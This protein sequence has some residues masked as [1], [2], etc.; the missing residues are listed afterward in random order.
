MYI[1]AHAIVLSSQ[2]LGEYDALVRVLSLEHGLLNLILR[3]VR[4]G[5]SR[6]K[7]LKE[8][9]IYAR[10]HCW[11]RPDVSA[12]PQLL[13]GRT[14]EIFD[15]LRRDFAL[16]ESMLG[17]LRFGEMFLTPYDTRSEEKF[18]LL[19]ETLSRLT[20]GGC[21]EAAWPALGFK[22]KMLELSGWRFSS[23]EPARGFLDA[24]MRAICGS[25][26]R[27]VFPADEPAPPEAALRLLD[28]YAQGLSGIRYGHNTAH[29]S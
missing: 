18:L 10:L 26:E 12:L 5:Q 29:V 1:D 2:P 28:G 24:K 19:L 13:T 9:G 4:R 6:L 14:I 8:P 3:G 22:L 15:G 20:C 16:F 23:S 11:A 25:L 21:Q 17:L 27:G 7:I